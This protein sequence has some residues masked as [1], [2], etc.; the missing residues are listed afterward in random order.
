MS[1]IVVGAIVYLV[2]EEGRVLLQRRRSGLFTGYIGLPGGKVEFGEA[3]EEAAL[4]ELREETGLRAST[5]RVLGVYSEV[6]FDHLKPSDHFVLFVVNTQNYVG[7]LLEHT[8]EGENFWVHPDRVDH[9][10]HVLP[11][12]YFVL[13]EVKRAPFVAS[14][15]RYN[16]GDTMY[17]VTSDGRRY[18]K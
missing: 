2:D 9:L 8:S 4:R 11:D 14:L 15:K 7:Q 12:L 16:D 10:D 3:V 5:P 13:D 6:N 18:P 17:V 1:G